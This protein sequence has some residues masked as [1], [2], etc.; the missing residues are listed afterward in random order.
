MNNTLTKA[1]KDNVETTETK[2]DTHSNQEEKG[3]EP[4]A[5]EREGVGDKDTISGHKNTTAVGRDKYTGTVPEETESEGRH[6]AESEERNGGS[7]KATGGSEDG[8]GRKEPDNSLNTVERQEPELGNTPGNPQGSP[9]TNF[10]SDKKET[11]GISG[12]KDKGQ[13]EKERKELQVNGKRDPDKVGPNDTKLRAAGGEVGNT[14]EVFNVEIT[15]N[16]TLTFETNERQT[17][18]NSVGS[19]DGRRGVPGRVNVTQY[20]MYRAGGE[21]GGS[22][23][24]KSTQT[25]EKIG[26]EPAGET[27][28]ELDKEEEA[29]E[30][31]KEANLSFRGERPV[32]L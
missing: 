11:T 15:E 3:Q 25:E 32:G 21:E 16:A 24:R 20:T 18:N 22:T 6:G 10:G 2:P 14:V 19:P 8:A 13:R 5:G 31:E 12:T 26:K 28:E 23:A 17:S 9:D 7:G 30:R 29:R 27:R 4:T 1:E